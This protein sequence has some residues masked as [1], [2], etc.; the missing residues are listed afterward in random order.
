MCGHT[1]YDWKTM[2]R[3]RCSAGSATRLSASN[4]VCSPTAIRPASG[5][6][7]PAIDISVVDLPQ[8]LGPSSVKSS[9]SSTSKL[10]S[11]SARWSPNSLTR[12]S[13]WISGT[14]LSFRDPDLEQLCADREHDHRDHDLHHGEGG[15]RADEPLDELR[16]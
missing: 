4:T 12:F 2:P 9:P 8:P 15:D 6:W 10:T 11:S 5:C 16:E 7:K 14:V 3:L 1:A 13:T